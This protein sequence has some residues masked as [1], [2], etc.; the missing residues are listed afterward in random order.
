MTDTWDERL[1]SAELYFPT[2]PSAVSIGH[3]LHSTVSRLE[4][5]G[6]YRT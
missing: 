5:G 1:H 2:L 6:G 4:P 3:H